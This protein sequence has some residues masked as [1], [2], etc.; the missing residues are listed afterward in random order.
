M[1]DRLVGGPVLAEA[2][3]VVGQH[4]DPPEPHEGGHP[5]RVPRV[6]GEDE[7]RSRV[8][9]DPAV[10]GHPVHDRA[11]RELAHPEVE[12]VPVRRVAGDGPRPRPAGQVRS[13]EVGGA[14]DELREAGGEAFECVLRRLAGGG[15]RALAVDLR[16][17][18]RARARPVAGESA[19]KPPVQ[20]VRKLRPRRPVGV[21][22]PAPRGLAPGAGGARIPARAHR[23]RYLEGG[24]RPAHRRPRPR[25]LVRSERGAVRRRRPRLGRRPPPDGGPAADE[26][27]PLAVAAR[28]L[29]RRLHRPPVVAVHA[30]D[31]LPAVGLE[32]GRGVVGEPA[33]HVAVDGDAVVVVEHGELAEP[34]RAREGAGLVRDPLH[35]AP[36]AREDPG[37]MVDDLVPRPVEARRE[38]ALDDGH[39]HRVREPLAERAGGGLHAGGQAELRMAGGAGMELAEALD[40]RHRQVVAREVQQGVDQHRAVAV[41]EHE[42]VPVRPR[43]VRGVVAE[44]SVPERLRD[45]RH[46]HRHPGVAGLR[47]FDRVHRE[48]AHRVRELPPR[49]RGRRRRG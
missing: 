46:P 35:Q 40:L 17:G 6:V 47:A 32:A 45:V 5:D 11:H 1:L 3:R 39:A 48:R 34:E 30:A 36:V 38:R 10:E 15:G 49:G 8:G 16:D 26:A 7:E 44:M 25:C 13:R 9:D 2:D 14:A 24:M 21:H 41:R 12:V 18:G 37:A 42:A 43:G 29:D 31:D 23:L 27:R 22:A 28:R 33:L 20:L 19:A 4:E